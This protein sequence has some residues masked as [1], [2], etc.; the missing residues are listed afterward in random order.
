M[1]KEVVHFLFGMRWLFIPS[2]P[3]S[4][5]LPDNLPITESISDLVM[6]LYAFLTGFGLCSLNQGNKN[7]ILWM[8]FISDPYGPPVAGRPACLGQGFKSRLRRDRLF[9]PA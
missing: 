8:A 6:D 7:A 4:F 2:V 3:F 1:G 9:D 5:Q